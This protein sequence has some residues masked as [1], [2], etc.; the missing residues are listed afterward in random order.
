MHNLAAIDAVLQY[1][2]ERPPS[3]R[4]A[5]MEMAALADDTRGIE[6]LF[7]HAH[8]TQFLIAAEDVADGLASA[9]LTMSF[10]SFTS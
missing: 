5:A 7:E 8:R 1:E 9:S 3:N 10:R 2:I 4:V 6:M